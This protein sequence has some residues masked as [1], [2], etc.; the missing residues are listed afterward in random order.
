MVGGAAEEA[1]PSLIEWRHARAQ[2]C[3][4]SLVIE[5][6]RSLPHPLLPHLPL[7]YTYFP[8]L[9]SKMCSYLN[10]MSRKRTL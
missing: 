7:P 9:R 3:T 2:V 5:P 4:G 8:L 10:S 1:P 6:A